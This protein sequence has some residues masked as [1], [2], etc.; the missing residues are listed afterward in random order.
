MQ[1]QAVKR[2]QTVARAS[3]RR[4]R[5]EA[6]QVRLDVYRQHI[7]AAAEQVF[8]ESGFESAK[9]QEIS[10]RVALSM[11][12]IYA[13]FPSKAELL[14]AILDKRGGDILALAR[15]VAA[16]NGPARETL[17]ALI[18]DYIG[19][20]AAHPDFLRMHLR[21]GTS[22]VLSPSPETESRV[23]MWRDVH[24][25]QTEIFRRG[26]AEGVFVDEDPALM[27][28]MFSA[29]DQVLLADWVESGMSA[30]K[31]SLVERFTRLV[32]R[33]FCR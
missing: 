10:R 14:Q 24:A 21:Q 22:W 20:F 23:R 8:A 3:G 16:R 17:R 1:K 6:R 25:L 15:A 27:A 31:A 33:A 13:L 4:P 2:K 12:T 11:G 19:Y 30:D 28:K 32:E 5:E 29:M 7:L 18:D 9:L 26:V